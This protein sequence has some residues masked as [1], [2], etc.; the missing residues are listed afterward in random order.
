MEAD[1]KRKKI[2]YPDALKLKV[3][4]TKN[5][6]LELVKTEEAKPEPKKPVATKPDPKPKDPKPVPL[7]DVRSGPVAKE[8]A[9]GPE[10]DKDVDPAT[11]PIAACFNERIKA[12]GV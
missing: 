7:K 12:G 9:K 1:A 5:L 4:D 6:T 11:D 8:T 10:V 3:A 2:P